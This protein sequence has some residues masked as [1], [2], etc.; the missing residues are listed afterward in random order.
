[1]KSKKYNL[2]HPTYRPDI[3]GLRAIAVLSVVGYH[4]FAGIVPG[5]FIGVDV[6]F[7]ISGFL[8]ST[9][10]LGNLDNN[11]FSYFEFYARR[12]KRIFPALLLVLL[13]SMAFGWYVLFPDEHSQLGK[14]VAGGAGFVSN[15]VLWSEAGYFDRAAEIKPLLHLW[16]L[17]IEE[18]F[19]ILWPLL[20]GI[21]WRRK[22]SFLLIAF[23][24]AAL[25]FV[26]NIYWIGRDPAALFFSPF[27][28]VW[29]LMVGGLL[30][31][32]FLFRC[33][34]PHCSNRLLPLF[35]PIGLVLI[36]CSVLW[37]NKNTP[38]PGWW[39]LVPT[40][41]SALVIAG[42]PTGWLNQFFLSH[43][44]MVWIGLISY[45]LYLWHWPLLAYARILERGLPD[46]T[47]RFSLIVASILLASGTYILVE[48]RF[49]KSYSKADISVLACSM[50]VLFIAGLLVWKG[51]VAP[52]AQLA[53]C[54]RG[55]RGGARLGLPRRSQAGVKWNHKCVYRNRKGSDN[56]VSWRFAY[57]AVRHES[58]SLTGRRS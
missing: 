51:G 8:I 41:G 2:A 4:Y 46:R 48:K 38:F 6:F 18:Q 25:S 3:D 52:K 44:I 54:R 34:K 45:P 1:M 27:S 29:E 57:S 35:A 22:L 12:I 28:R 50:F 19:Y 21:V 37:F 23:L 30:A 5:G 43:P 58:S 40:I 24:V 55:S 14:H 42:H 49:R 39:A 31:Y 20:L 9:I 56:V 53:L 17:G 26:I 11:R 7:V 13:S 33:D 15:F 47:I 36:V 16:S 32:V 10:I